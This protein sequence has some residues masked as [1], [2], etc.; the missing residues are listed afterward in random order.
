M[1]K[2]GEELSRNMLKDTWTKTKW[3]GSRV[4]GGDGWGRMEWGK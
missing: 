1:G 3:V 2:I 4:G